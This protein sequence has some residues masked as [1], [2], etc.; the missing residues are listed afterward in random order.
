[1]IR[2]IATD[3]GSSAQ[4]PTALNRITVNEP[5]ERLV[6]YRIDVVDAIIAEHVHEIDESSADYTN[7]GWCYYTH[8]FIWSTPACFNWIWRFF[9]TTNTTP[10]WTRSFFPIVFTR[11]DQEA[12]WWLIHQLWG[13]VLISSFW[14]RNYTRGIDTPTPTTSRTIVATCHFQNQRQCIR[15]DQHGHQSHFQMR[16]ACANHLHH[17]HHLL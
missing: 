17:Q 4:S 7:N 12:V 16:R 3:I 2:Q 10:N 13:V 8:S 15:Q 9:S 1:M 14:R 5:I 11:G 6:D